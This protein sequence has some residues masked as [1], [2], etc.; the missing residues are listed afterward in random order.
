[1]PAKMTSHLTFLWFC[2]RWGVVFL[3]L[4]AISM[5][6]LAIHNGAGFAEQ[7]RW[8]HD[9]ILMVVFWKVSLWIVVA[10]VGGWILERTSAIRVFDRIPPSFYYT[11][12]FVIFLPFC[13]T[14][15]Q[16]FGGCI[17]FYFTEHWWEQY[18]P[19]D[20][21]GLPRVPYQVIIYTSLYLIFSMIFYTISYVLWR[22][23]NLTQL[24]NN[25][26]TTH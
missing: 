8:F 26:L 4:V 23:G 14:F 17:W 12:A 16:V 24:K 21:F 6:L 13:S 2:A 19:I 7:W 20:F 22:K 11:L 1:M 3:G 5:Y 9:A 10:F 25:T 15:S 18:I